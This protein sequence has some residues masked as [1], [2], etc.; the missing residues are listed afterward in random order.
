MRSPFVPFLTLLLLAGCESATAPE[1]TIEG[2]GVPD[3]KAITVP[4]PGK[5]AFSSHDDG[6]WEIYVISP[7]GSGR[8]QLT[9]N[10]AQ[11]DSPSW[12][13]SQRLVFST[14]R[15]GSGKSDLYSIKP[16]G[17]QET[18]LTTS[19]LSLFLFE[20]TPAWSPDGSKIA[21]V[22]G[23][24]VWV[25]NA[26]GTAMTNLTN[27]PA[28][29]SNPTWSADGTKIAFSSTRNGPAQLYVMN[30]NGSAPTQITY[31]DSLGGTAIH[32]DWSPDGQ[33][34]AFTWTGPTDDEVEIYMVKPDGTQVTQVTNT[35]DDENTPTWSPDSKRIA[36]LKG[37]DIWT[38]KKDGTGLFNVTSTPGLC[39]NSSAWSR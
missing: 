9:H 33:W 30:A 37:C 2:P 28:F 25:M 1:P 26:D 19:L 4:T 36:F 32:A 14:T 38:M 24:D 29:D 11:D 20:T 17:T 6:D 12:L 34:I 3:A 7:N 10:T 21:F 27:H 15:N 23:W 22:S 8:T 31:Y 39:E 13:G 18:Q 16:D 35:P 5:I